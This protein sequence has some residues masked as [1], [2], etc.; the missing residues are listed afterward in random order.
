MTPALEPI[1]AHNTIHLCGPCLRIATGSNEPLLR[2]EH[3]PAGPQI[4]A[5]KLCMPCVVNLVNRLNLGPVLAAAQP[6]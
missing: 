1:S 3:G 6:Q 5:P 2:V 4:S